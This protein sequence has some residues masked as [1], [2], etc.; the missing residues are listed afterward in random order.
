MQRQTMTG[1]AAALVLLLAATG[2]AAAQGGPEIPWS[3]IGGGGADHVE[4]G[5]GVVIV[6]DTLG[7]SVVGRADGGS[8]NLDAGYRQ[9]L[10]A[11]AAITDVS[12]S[13][14]T[15]AGIRYLR[16]DWTAVTFDAGGH[17]IAG[18]TYD[19]YRAQ[20]D[21]YFEPVS[22]WVTSLADPNWTDPDTTVL[23]VP[24]HSTY[25]VVVA[26]YNGLSSGPSNRTGAFVFALTPGG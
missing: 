7:Q 13:V 24:A 26:V 12:A 23:T 6:N 16:L 3:V 17:T 11:P 18:V 8:V 5:G 20:D 9:Q 19:V 1:L 21:P 22:A 2:G 10:F 25:Y 15:E 4:G 14:V